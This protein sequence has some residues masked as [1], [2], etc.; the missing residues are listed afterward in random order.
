[1]AFHSALHR[2][3]SGWSHLLFRETKL[4][5]GQEEL[6]IGETGSSNRT[7]KIEERAKAK[8][9]ES[10]KERVKAKA[11]KAIPATTGAMTTPTTKHGGKDGGEEVK[12]DLRKFE[13]SIMMYAKVTAV[14]LKA[15]QRCQSKVAKPC[16]QNSCM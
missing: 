9:K 7:T 5:G 11:E 12:Y 4:Q 14:M 2:L 16:F 6:R 3:C 1:M 8:A 13:T 15:K 10:T